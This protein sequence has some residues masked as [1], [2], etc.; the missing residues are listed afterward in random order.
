MPLSTEPA[1]KV[2]LNAERQ[3]KD[4]LCGPY[5][6]ARV[7]REAGVAA[8]QGDPLDQDLVALHAGTSLPDGDG[9]SEVP[10]RAVSRHD[11]RCSLP[12][13]EPS[14]AGTPAP[15][16]AAAVEKLSGGELACLPVSGEWSATIVEELVSGVSEVRLIA[17][18]RTGRLWGSR[19]PIE[20]LLAALEGCEVPEAP[21]PDWDVGHYVEL[22]QLLR[23]RRGSL[24]L[25]RDSYPE[26]GWGGVHA[27]PPG[28]LAAALMRGDGREGG[29]LAVGRPE[30]V[31][32]VADLLREL[33]LQ[34]RI[35]D[36]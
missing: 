5:H 13:V 31:S 36:N 19:P 32:S 7:L 15:G 27:Q 25:V 6:A 34:A 18:L 17:N 16:L 22:L 3:Q 23:G 14:R 11:Y 29:V 26:L 8:W 24:V 28:A 9:A 33:G 30:R 4:Y 21:A 20:S 1:A 12:R 2:K 10:P 35:W